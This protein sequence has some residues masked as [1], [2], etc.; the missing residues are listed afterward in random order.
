MTNATAA[1]T[2]FLVV[3]ESH[4][5]REAVL[6]ADCLP[7]QP[8]VRGRFASVVEIDADALAFMADLEEDVCEVCGV[9]GAR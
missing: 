1:A 5:D 7:T 9:K 8:R 4:M 2:L 6:C 3:A